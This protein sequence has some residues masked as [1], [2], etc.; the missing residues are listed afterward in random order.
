[1]IVDP[2]GRI[3]TSAGEDPETITAELTKKAIET[4]R[5]KLPALQSRRK[6]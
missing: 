6:R 4:T 5:A 2:W 1:M 3:V